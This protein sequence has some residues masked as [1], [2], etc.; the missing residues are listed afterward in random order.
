MFYRTHMDTRTLSVE[1]LVSS[2]NNAGKP[3]VH[4]QKVEPRSLAL[5]VCKINSK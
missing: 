3:D 5:T 2:V 1:R 4:M